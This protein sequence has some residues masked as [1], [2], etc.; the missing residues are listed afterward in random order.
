MMVY[1]NMLLQ[2]MGNMWSNIDLFNDD[3]AQE[4]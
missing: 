3:V 4:N 1:I 2:K